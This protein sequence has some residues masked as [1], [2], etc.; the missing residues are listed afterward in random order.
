MAMKKR[1]GKS[2][3]QHIRDFLGENPKATP[4]EIVEG[5]G[6]QGVKVS[7]GLAANVKHTSGFGGKKRRGRKKMVRRKRPGGQSVDISALQA[8]AKYV[9]Q[10]GDI[11]AA[12]TAVQQVKELQVG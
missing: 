10:V 3:S 11:D 1:K 7:P 8:A 9:Q 2:L 12:I 6:K 5:L 4:S